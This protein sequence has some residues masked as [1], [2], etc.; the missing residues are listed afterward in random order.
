MYYRCYPAMC[1]ALLGHLRTIEDSNA[2]STACYINLIHVLKVYVSFM[3]AK[4]APL[5][6]APE[7]SDLEVS[8]EDIDFVDEYSQ[9]LGFLTSLN[10]EQIDRYCIAIKPC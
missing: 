5:P 1:G 7:Q 2:C 10:R 4:A 6:Q 9:R 8:D 3:Q